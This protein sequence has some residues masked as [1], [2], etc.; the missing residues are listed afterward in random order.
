LKALLYAQAKHGTQAAAPHQSQIDY[1]KLRRPEAHQHRATKHSTQLLPLAHVPLTQQHYSEK[2]EQ[3]HSVEGRCEVWTALSE[4]LHSDIYAML[5]AAPAAKQRVKRTHHK[6]DVKPAA[7]AVQPFVVKPRAD[8]LAAEVQALVQELSRAEQRDSSERQRCVR[9]AS[10]EAF[11][12]LAAQEATAV[13]LRDTALTAATA[14]RGSAHSDSSTATSSDC[15]DFAAPQGEANSTEAAANA[16]TVCTKA[17]ASTDK[18][19]DSTKLQCSAVLSTRLAT[20]SNADAVACEQDSSS[21]KQTCSE[22]QHSRDAAD[23]VVLMQAVMRGF[24]DRTRVKLLLE[25]Q[26]NSALINL[27]GGRISKVSTCFIT[28]PYQHYALATCS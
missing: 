18:S 7:A 20:D 3:A 5:Q 11:W 17:S 26:L 21:S 10:S 4:E 27:G 25:Q 19:S 16:I 22:Q 2:L 1:V 23:A 15:D 28:K 24:K 8:A 13:A 6:T 14:T 12:Q 9:A